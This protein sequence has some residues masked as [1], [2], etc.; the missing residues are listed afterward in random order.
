MCPRNTRYIPINRAPS[1]SRW[2]TPLTDAHELGGAVY[3]LPSSRSTYLRDQPEWRKITS[4]VLSGRSR[5]SLFST[6]ASTTIRRRETLARAS[7]SVA[8]RIFALYST[9]RNRPR[10]TN[11]IIVRIESR[12]KSHQSFDTQSTSALTLT[13]PGLVTLSSR[14]LVVPD[15]CTQLR[16]F[17]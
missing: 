2:N 5:R 6:V 8:S 11:S 15:I 1:A 3:P 17:G 9:R 12:I 4:I 16:L 7:S 14:S 13:E 10:V